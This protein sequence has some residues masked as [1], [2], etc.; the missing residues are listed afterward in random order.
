MMSELKTKKYKIYFEDENVIEVS[1]YKKNM[2]SYNAH[3][4]FCDFQNEEDLK[5]YWKTIA[6]EIAIEYQSQN[7]SEIERANFYIGYFSQVP[8]SIELQ[9]TIEQD[10]YCA[11]KYVFDRYEQWLNQRETIDN[12]I[13]ELNLKDMPVKSNRN[14]LYQIDLQNFR[15]YAGK[16]IFDLTDSEGNPASF[17]LIYAP[18]GVGKTSFMEGI[19]FALKG[20]V[21]RLLDLEKQAKHNGPIYHH[22]DRVD[23]RAYVQLFVENDSSE[24]KIYKPR[25]VPKFE[26]GSDTNTDNRSYR[27][28]FKCSKKD[29]D[30]VILPHDKI[31]TFI[32]ANSPE[33]R[34]ES[35]TKNDK[36]ISD[37]AEKLKKVRKTLKDNE[38]A[39]DDAVAARESQERLINSLQSKRE[40]LSQVIK[41]IQEYN[42]LVMKEEEKLPVVD[43][44]AGVQVYSNLI[45]EARALLEESQNAFENL[46]TTDSQMGDWVKVGLEKCDLRY[47]EFQ[48]KKKEKQQIKKQR[49]LFDERNQIE[50]QLKQLVERLHILEQSRLPY[51]NLETY[52]IEKIFSELTEWRKITAVLNSVDKQILEINSAIL[53]NEENI[54]RIERESEEL[55][56]LVKNEEIALKKAEQLETQ[57]KQLNSVE[58]I[59]KYIAKQEDDEVSKRWSFDCSILHEQYISDDARN[60]LSE[61]S[62]QLV[63]IKERFYIADSAVHK[64]LTE[65]IEQEAVIR[66]LQEQAVEY[67]ENNKDHCRCPVC[68][69]KFESWEKLILSIQSI[70]DN[71]QEAYQVRLSKATEEK[72]NIWQ[73]YENAFNE[74]CK[75]LAHVKERLLEK[76]K[77]LE[78]EIE[79]INEWLSTNG[80]I[81][82]GLSNIV[83]C[84]TNYYISKH[85]RLA[86]N[87]E[88]KKQLVDKNVVLKNEK[89]KLTEEK[90]SNQSKLSS[91]NSEHLALLKNAENIEADYRS[92]KWNSLINYAEDCK[93]KVDELT[94][95]LKSFDEEHNDI[96]F[97]SEEMLKENSLSTEKWIK[98][99]ISFAEAY[100]PYFQNPDLLKI[101][102]QTGEKQ[103]KMYSERVSKLR[104]IVNEEGVKDYLSLWKNAEA[105]YELKKREEFDTKKNYQ[106]CQEMNDE[107]TQQLKQQLEE[108]FSQENANIIYQKIDPNNDLTDMNFSLTFTEDN[109]PQLNYE[110][111]RKNQKGKGYTA[112]LY[113]STA[114]LNAVAFSSF[115]ARALT[116][117]QLDIHSIIIDDPIGSF[118]DMNILGFSDLIRS[119]IMHTD[120]QIIMTTHDSKIFDIMQRKLNCKYHSSR[121]YRLP[122]DLVTLDVNDPEI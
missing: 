18:N 78:D 49:E 117:T 17:V 82:S 32:T 83:E 79:T 61:I 102:R 2:G 98:E 68:H 13:F 58:T 12:H 105:D 7:S 77:Y 103:C 30:M 19:E 33:K 46:V 95:L 28:V 57:R 99:N 41:M 35:W 36:K 104:R 101:K 112:E 114:Q 6:N 92:G 42:M 27:G 21:D 56:T 107:L 116:E 31:D 15:G 47:K 109:R 111:T 108:Y 9:N 8:V 44:N 75:I 34:Y 1:Y 5:N 16:N 67:L 29:W 73:E 48:T 59:L 84:V 118:D 45:T 110:M 20:E 25:Q 80:I 122:E 4:F 120:V 113:L 106:Q 115:F 81:Y 26:N 87:H 24:K 72:E 119:I 11:R 71:E 63:S 52:G 97:L 93:K 50:R 91:W 22:Y 40:G 96:V 74:A 89:E 65:H 10:P 39:R 43:S 3:V 86:Y 88:S 54:G 76:K 62:S 51:I 55:T 66:N 14:K 37:T 53:E 69:S 121:F 85:T 100:E 23:Q 60:R 94:N 64:L 70:E 90:D 38:R